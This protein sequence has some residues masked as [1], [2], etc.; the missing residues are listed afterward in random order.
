MFLLSIFYAVVTLHLPF[1]HIW[2]GKERS[3]SHYWYQASVSCS[4]PT[5]NGYA[6]CILAIEGR[7]LSGAKHEILI[8][9]RL[10][11]TLDIGIGDRVVAMASALDGKV[12]SD[13]L[14]VVGLYQSANSSFDRMCIYIPLEN[15][16]EILRVGY[17]ISE[18]AVIANDLNTVT[19]I[20]N[21][22][23]EKLG[24]SYEVLSYH[25]LIPSLLSQMEILEQSMFIFY[26][27]IGLSMI[28]GII[29]TILM[30]VFE[31]IQEFGC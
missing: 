3:S 8:S 12:G 26:F 9:E 23:L 6:P 5:I 24:T 31:R 20:K 27:I 11:E 13:M 2:I 21:D 16:Q 14:R 28:F 1:R 4:E 29:N 15:A 10:S 17:Q 30:S 25:D 19:A 22:L 18:I 7:Y